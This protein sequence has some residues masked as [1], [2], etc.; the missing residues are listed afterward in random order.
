MWNVLFDDRLHERRV[1]VR[2]ERAIL[3]QHA[4][5]SDAPVDELRAH[6]LALDGQAV[7]V[8]RSARD[9]RVPRLVVAEQIVGGE[10]PLDALAVLERRALR[11]R[12]LVHHAAEDDDGVV[13]LSRTARVLRRRLEPAED[14]LL[15]DVGREHDEHRDAGDAEGARR[16]RALR[17]AARRRGAK[18]PRDRQREQDHGPRERAQEQIQRLRQEEEHAPS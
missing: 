8:E 12:A 7:H 5:G 13:F 6:H 18:P 3:E 4:L 17:R 2:V 1:L 14:R 15:G 11:A 10:D 9:D 16:A